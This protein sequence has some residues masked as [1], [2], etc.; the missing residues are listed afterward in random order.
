MASK[1]GTTPMRPW[2]QQL[3]EYAQ[4]LA[5]LD[6]TVDTKNTLRTIVLQSI[7]KDDRYRDVKRD[8][9]RHP[10]WGWLDLRTRLEAAA[11]NVNDLLSPLHSGQGGYRPPRYPP[12]PYR[13]Y[14]ARQA[15]V[16]GDTPSAGHESDQE[17]IDG[18]R[19]GSDSLSSHHSRTPRARN[20]K[21][22][23]RP[24]SQTSQR[25]P[26]AEGPSSTQTRLNEKKKRACTE[27]LATGQC[28]RGDACWFAHRPHLRRG[29]AC[30]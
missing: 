26:K 10:N 5:D 19:S 9:M 28:E 25:R 1:K 22:H 21:A 8:I 23:G 11:Q 14:E 16:R 17:S 20:T 29:K 4:G 7:E 27:Y 2:L 18:Y 6:Q 12:R 13:P 3:A 30:A 24:R 15:L